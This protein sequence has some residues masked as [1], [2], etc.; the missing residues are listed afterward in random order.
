MPVI[1]RAVRGNIGLIKHAQHGMLFHTPSE[2]IQQ[3][4]LLLSDTQLLTRLTQSGRK[5]VDE[6]YSR[7]KEREGYV[8]L[9]RDML[10]RVSATNVT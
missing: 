3:A 9:V 1:A 6:N 7:D 2:F 10:S 5:F 8:Q 4:Q